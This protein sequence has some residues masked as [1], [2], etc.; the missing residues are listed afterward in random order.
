MGPFAEPGEG[1]RKHAMAAVAQRIGHIAPAPPAD[2][3]AMYDYDPSA[4]ACHAAR[5]PMR[6]SSGARAEPWPFRYAKIV[7]SFGVFPIVTAVLAE[8]GFAVHAPS[9][10]GA[11][12]TAA[13]NDSTI[14]NPLTASGF[15][16]DN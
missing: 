10:K 11:A 15:Q 5:S 13:R 7:P 16:S 12:K 4:L 14:F 3:C 6:L 8:V 1:G 9:G 2:P